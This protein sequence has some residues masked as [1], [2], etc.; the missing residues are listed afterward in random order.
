MATKKTTQRGG[1]TKA[2]APV[3]A[4][5][6]AKPKKP[7][8]AATTKKTATKPIPVEKAAAK[9]VA[10]RPVASAPRPVKTGKGAAP[11]DVGRSLVELAR[12]GRGSEVEKKWWSPNVVSIEGLGL[13]MEWIGSKAA[14][15]K[16]VEWEADHIVHG[17]EIEGPF[18]GAS[19]FAVRF[20][21]EV[22]TK[23]T[24][25]HEKMEEVGVYTVENGK[26]VREEFMYRAG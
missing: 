26:I 23:S 1:A 20:K 18:V 13:S 22:E 9:K 7:M 19:G 15:Q 5:A 10:P 8:P 3:K 16:A 24:G 25:Q 4:S 6:P 12:G 2:I 14:H 11:L 17:V 21:M